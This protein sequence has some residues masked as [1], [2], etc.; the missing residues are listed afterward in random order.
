MSATKPIDVKTKIK[1]PGGNSEVSIV[2][3]ETNPAQISHGIQLFLGS[4][5]VKTVVPF[6]V[7]PV[8]IAHSLGAANALLGLGADCFGR[9]F[10]PAVMRVILRCDFLMNGAVIGKSDDA[11]IDLTA[12]A[13]SRE[14]H[15]RCLFE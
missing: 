9:V 14:F 8:G 1:L 5:L 3:V 2:L 7:N 10:H 15:I 13:S 12:T 6:G 4:N 11:T